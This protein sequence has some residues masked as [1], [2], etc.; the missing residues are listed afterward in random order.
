MSRLTTEALSVDRLVKEVGTPESGAVATFLGVV[1]NHHGGRGVLRLIYEAKPAMAQKIMDE[2]ETEAVRRFGVSRCRIDH[3]IG[4]LG[5]GEAS[6]AIAVSSPHRADAIRACEWAI[7]T[8]KETVPI[9]KK[10][11]FADGSVEWVEGCAAKP[12]PKAD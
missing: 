12:V 3:R 9:W 10:E 6:V 11:F 8:L 1:R 4:E 2:L 5:I 7:N